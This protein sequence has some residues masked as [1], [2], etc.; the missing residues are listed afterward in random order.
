MTRVQWLEACLSWQP[1][2]T[3]QQT[4]GAEGGAPNP[5]PGASGEAQLQGGGLAER[6]LA[7]VAGAGGVEERARA[8]KAVADKAVAGEDAWRRVR[9]EGW[10]RGTLGGMGWGWQA[11]SGKQGSH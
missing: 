11:S 9:G 6:A 1:S 10:V 3:P 2:D 5:S 8:A 4:G 7:A